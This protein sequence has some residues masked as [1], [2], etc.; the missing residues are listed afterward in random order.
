MCGHDAASNI[1]T[2]SFNASIWYMYVPYSGKLSRGP[3]FVVFADDRLNAKIK[4]TK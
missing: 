4:P 3:I 1:F 2:V